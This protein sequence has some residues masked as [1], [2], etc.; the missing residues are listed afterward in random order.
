MAV[1]SCRIGRATS[2]MKNSTRITVPGTSAATCQAETRCARRV[3]SCRLV[4]S[5]STNADN[6]PVSSVTRLRSSAN[7]AIARASSAS[8]R[9]AC[10]RVV[11][12]R[13]APAPID[14]ASAADS[15]RSVNGA[16]S[17]RRASIVARSWRSSCRL[18]GLPSTWYWRATRSSEPTRS[19][20]SRLFSA[21]ATPVNTSRSLCAA[22]RSRLTSAQITARSSGRPTS[23]NPTRIRPLSDL[24]RRNFMREV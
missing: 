10:S 3:L 2:T 7:S 5:V 16:I 6:V 18:S 9:F 19:T 13:R 15:A 11:T 21:A 23:P 22:S 4:S 17:A 8:L 24:G 1:S 12:I 14:A 20:S